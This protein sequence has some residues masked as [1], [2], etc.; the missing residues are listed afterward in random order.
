MFIAISEEPVDYIYISTKHLGH[1]QYVYTLARNCAHRLVNVCTCED[2]S[3]F[4]SEDVLI[5]IR[6][7]GDYTE[8][9]LKLL[10]KGKGKTQARS[11]SRGQGAVFIAQQRFFFNLHTKNGFT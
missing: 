4:R 6:V 8:E 7:V 5:R 10:A 11:F 9:N 1:F 2:L 3:D